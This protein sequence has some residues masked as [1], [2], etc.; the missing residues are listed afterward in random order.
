MTSSMPLSCAKKIVPHHTAHTWIG[1][2]ADRTVVLYG[3]SLSLNLWRNFKYL[4]HNGGPGLGA[5]N[6]NL[7]VAGKR[8][9]ALCSNGHT[10]RN[11]HSSH[12]ATGAYETL[13]GRLVSSPTA[14]STRRLRHLRST[15][16][17]CLLRCFM[18]RNRSYAKVVQAKPLPPAELRPTHRG[19]QCASPLCSSRSFPAVDVAL[20]LPPSVSVDKFKLRDWAPREARH[21]SNKS[22]YYVQLITVRLLSFRGGDDAS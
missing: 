14:Q 12:A 15:L 21:D 6:T 7:A 4:T 2:H 3:C 13:R 8:Q 16:S 17:S 18:G 5:H 9:G 22:T 11:H 10:G 19:P 1:T 20:G